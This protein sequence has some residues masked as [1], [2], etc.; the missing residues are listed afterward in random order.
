MTKIK[1]LPPRSGKP[2]KLQE[3]AVAFVKSG[4]GHKLFKSIESL[5]MHKAQQ[6]QAKACPR[7]V[8]VTS[9]GGE[10]GF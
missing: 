9:C 1:A 2:G 5:E 7:K 3:M 4:W 10:E 6:N 8:M